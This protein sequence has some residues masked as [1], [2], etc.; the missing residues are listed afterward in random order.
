MRIS[1]L[2][3]VCLS[4]VLVSCGKESPT[5][6]TSD[7]KTKSK[8][9][10]VVAK[11]T[12]SEGK[13]K[14]TQTS[15]QPPDLTTAKSLPREEFEAGWIKLFD[16]QTLFGWKANSDADWRVSNGA[17]VADKGTA[18]LLVTN[19]PFADYEFR[20]EYHLEKGGNSGVF[21]RTVFNPKDPARDCYELN[22]CDTHPAFQTGSLVARKKAD[23]KTEGEGEWK[24]FHVVLKGRQITVKLDDRTVLDFNDTSENFRPS[25]LIGLQYRE[26]KIEFRNILLKPLGAK[27]VFN[28]KDLTGWKTIPGSKGKITVEDSALRMKDGKGFLQSDSVHADFIL[29]TDVKTHAS[30]VNSG[31]FFRSIAGTEDQPANGYELQVH[32]G[33]K[34][35]DRTQPDDYKTGFGTGAIFRFAKVRWVVPNDNE[36]FTMT[37][38]AHGNRFATWVNGHQVTD[39][40]DDR[41]PNENPR[42][43]LRLKAGHLI[44]QSH[45]DEADVSFRNLRVTTFPAKSAAKP[46]AKKK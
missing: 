40:A 10:S 33:F 24:K 35:G 16:D 22:M 30:Q 46:P 3:S 43:G 9:E 8:S 21:L 20:C 14:K 11:K 15:N 6:K 12:K 42:R 5:K 13:G 23:V 45:D 25:G 18:G 29:Q 27:T 26:G 31:I 17:I 39:W 37:L 41:K 34:N 36:W 38:I 1:F 2:L 7:G 4:V 44:L 28:G 32:N 19:V